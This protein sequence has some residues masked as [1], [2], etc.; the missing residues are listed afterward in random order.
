MTFV[1]FE[2]SVNVA[3]CGIIQENG[4]S[5]FAAI[6][7]DT[8]VVIKINLKE[9]NWFLKFF[10]ILMHNLNGG[11]IMKGLKIGFVIIC[12]AILFLGA[13][14]DSA[15]AQTEKKWRMASVCNAE[16][17]MTIMCN[18]FIE[19]LETVSN[20]K[21]KVT[22]YD[23]GKLGHERET[24]EQIQA[25]A[26][27]L[28][29]LTG[30]VLANFAPE[31]GLYTLPYLFTT[32]EQC[33]AWEGT[34]EA[35]KLRKYLEKAGFKY[36]AYE[37]LLFR[38]VMVKNKP[39][40][41]LEDMKGVK[42]RVLENPTFIQTYK[43]MG[44]TPVPISFSEVFTSLETNIIDGYETGIPTF[45][46]TSAWE[47]MK[48]LSMT[49]AFYDV[50]FIVMDLKLYDSLSA[51]EKEWVDEAASIAIQR[52]IVLMNNLFT[53]SLKTL[54]AHGVNVSYPDLNSLENKMEPIYI[55][56]YEQFPSLKPI[57]EKAIS[58]KI[59]K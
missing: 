58:L 19:A 47:Q 5:V 51:A 57:V 53:D 10:L 46:L 2:N 18:Y 22:L 30:G 52:E 3:H 13:F 9:V 50:C 54:K 28:A 17:P 41:T 23:S 11:N 21:I 35:K 48:Q 33:V 16:D 8:L 43:S 34:N 31:W 24:S 55:K 1:Q 25:H 42:I 49:T 26:L 6:G 36:I 59:K 4:W 14:S 44:F 56:F 32:Q 38:H 15:M 12:L 20:G 27:D 37:P 45:A 7:I 29:S 39:L 40:K